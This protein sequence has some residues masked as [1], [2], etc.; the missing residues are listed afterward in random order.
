MSTRTL[1]YIIIVLLAINLLGLVV[2]VRQQ[3]SL[4]ATLNRVRK[5]QQRL[6]HVECSNDE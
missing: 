5:M 3:R 1:D 2:A 6:W 4:R